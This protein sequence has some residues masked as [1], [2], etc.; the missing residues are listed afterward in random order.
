MGRARPGLG[1]HLGIF[2][3]KRGELGER[4]SPANL[5]VGGRDAGWQVLM[6]SDEVGATICLDQRVGD[7]HLARHPWVVALEFNRLD[8]LGI[9]HE[10]QEPTMERVGLRARLTGGR[11]RVVRQRDAKRPALR[12]SNAWIWLVI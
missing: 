10:L 1:V 8:H 6:H 3:D 11:R 4:H 7:R 2:L 9:G 5:V 12:A